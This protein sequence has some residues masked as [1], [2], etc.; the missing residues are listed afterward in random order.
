MCN[1]LF[2]F[3]H[4]QLFR[5]DFLSAHI[6]QNR[7]RQTPGAFRRGICALLCCSMTLS[8]P[9][10]ACAEIRSGVIPAAD[11]AYY[12]MLDYYGNPTDA[13]VVKSY[14]L[15]GAREITDYGSYDSVNNLTD[16]T[17]A[18]HKD[19]SVI[20][21]FGDSAPDHF[22]FEGKTEAPFR[23]LPWTLSLSY[24]LNGVPKEAS[25]LAGQKGM[26]EISVKAVPNPESSAYM[27]NNWFLSAVSAF[28]Q[29]DILSLEAP[30]AQLQTLGN[31][32]I[33]AF[34][35]LPGE[36]KEFTL[37]V[38][39]ES[40]E[41]D[42]MTF[43]MGP[44]NA[45]G[46][47]KELSDL[48]K[49]KEDIE[50]SWDDLNGAFDEVLDS[51]D[52]MKGNLNGAAAGLDALDSVRA[53]VHSNQSRFYGDL[54]RFLGSMDALSAALQPL[55]GH[56]DAANN[57]VTDL[58]GN[59]NELNTVLLSLKQHLSETKTTLRALSGDMQ[60]LQDV[61]AD[62]DHDSHHVKNDIENL[63]S[64][65]G[66]GKSALD[67]GIS[68]TLSQMTQLYQA[69]AAYMKANGLQ[70]VDAFGDGKVLY[71][72]D[73]TG[74]G[75]ATPSSAGMD[76]SYRG[77]GSF[78]ITG[79]SFPEGSFQDFAIEKL[80]SL[81]YDSD[82]IGYA[83]TLWNYRDDI[84]HISS[85]A[86][87]VYGGAD[88]L[89]NSLLSLEL[90]ALYDLMTDVGID[91]QQGFSQSVDIVS[92]ITESIDR[93][94]RL[95]STIDSYLPELQ[96]TLS[97]T[98]ALCRTLS[99]SSA[100]LSAFLRTSRNIMRENSDTLNRGTRDSLANASALLKKSAEALDST[101]RMRQA[102]KS[103]NDLVDEKWDEHTGEKTNLFRLEADAPAESLTSPRNTAVSSISV[104]IRSAEIKTEDTDMH[105]SSGDDSDHRTI[106]QRIAQMFV[107]LW[108]LLTGWMHH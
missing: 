53:D 58:R 24:R 74:S 41:Y 105:L 99:E 72:L 71:D 57:T 93:I 107:D 106:L 69:Y 63:Q 20:F 54:D 67:S 21:R 86:D 95:H 83:I 47:L 31:I 36:E 14:A 29:D 4:R 37:R 17:P 91:G 82:E 26:V 19:D 98:A 43:M 89:A 33:A 90:E 25:E 46:R 10:S 78:D 3:L 51:L 50:D 100:S 39:T 11:E 96:S 77:N 35:W 13:S 49:D 48:R 61:A 6:F 18:E 34:F 80:S 55:S 22:Y 75:T 59:L 70:P 12:V 52:N 79:I 15:N 16:S 23:V 104:L 42:G 7:Q 5:A 76:L 60:K 92:D 28:N 65:T 38:G 40:F 66:K 8:A 101:E 27:R 73:T 64:L 45:S 97:D 2:H 44:V 85:G 84:R 81:G 56:A 30:D 9:F 108:Q 68:G 62:L 88:R 87:S 102:K 1:C 103:I 32:R 94:D